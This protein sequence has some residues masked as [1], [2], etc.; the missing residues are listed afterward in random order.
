MHEIALVQD[1]MD[2]AVQEVGRAGLTGRIVRLK[3]SVGRLS[4]ASSEALRFAFDVLSPGTCAEGASLE[5]DEV[6]GLCRCR[7]CGS[8]RPSSDLLASCA[9]CGSPDIVLEGGRD[10]VL[11]SIDVEDS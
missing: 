4:C 11:T 9:E 6:D 10:L 3:L 2:T 1:L 5:I 8:T 7:A